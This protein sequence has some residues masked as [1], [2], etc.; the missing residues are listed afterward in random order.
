MDPRQQATPQQSQPAPNKDV[1]RLTGLKK[2]QQIE[3]AGRVVFVWI[4]IAA[5][6][7]SFCAATGQFLLA[8]WLHNNKVITAKHQAV[9]ILSSSLGNAKELTQEVDA[10]VANEALASVK[11]EATDPNTKSVLDALPTTF[12]PAALATSL[13]QAIL[14]RSGVGIDNIS[15]PQEVGEATPVVDSIPQEM[16]F[17]FTVSGSYEQI[18]QAVLDVERTIRPMRITSFNLVG[19]DQDLRAS[20]DAVTYFQPAKSVELKKETVK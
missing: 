10:L 7:L 4:A 18:K 13:Q 12:D 8:K 3:V 6:A 20:V 11:T 16:A 14:N 1:P 15:V 5:A 19:S 9:G 2:R 17:S